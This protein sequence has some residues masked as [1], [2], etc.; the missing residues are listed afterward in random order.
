LDD[1]QNNVKLYPRWQEYLRANQAASAA[2]VGGRTTSSSSPEGAR[3]YLH[4]LPEAEL[5][6]LDTGH[7]ATATH[8]DEIA[9]LITAFLDRHVTRGDVVYA[10]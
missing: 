4:D 5:H 2:S 3:A 7:F 10:R 6:L 8:H 1:Y 9:E